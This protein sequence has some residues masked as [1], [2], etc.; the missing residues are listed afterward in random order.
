MTVTVRP[1]TWARRRPVPAESRRLHPCKDA[2]GETR[3]IHHTT[4]YLNF[5][6]N[7]FLRPKDAINSMPE[8]HS[9]HLTTDRRLS[10]TMNFPTRS[11]V[12]LNLRSD[13]KFGER[14]RGTR[15]VAA[16]QMR[17]PTLQLSAPKPGFSTPMPPGIHLFRRHFGST[18]K[19]F[20]G[21]PSAPSRFFKPKRR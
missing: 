11:D 18:F 20:P 10:K 9:H 17:A 19:K 14:R 1:L 8:P 12:S 21:H 13:Q 16:E 15:P 4:H 7:P 5:M 2:D 3:R 6:S